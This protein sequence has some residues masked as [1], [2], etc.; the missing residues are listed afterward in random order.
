MVTTQG[1]LLPDL[2]NERERRELPEK[3]K[4]VEDIAFS[5]WPACTEPDPGD[6]SN[7]PFVA[8]AIISNPVS[9]GHIHCAEA[10][11]IPL[12]RYYY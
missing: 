4:M 3:V 2:T 6:S 10:L 1:R 12:V 7:T 5:T 9:Y 11:G 8:D